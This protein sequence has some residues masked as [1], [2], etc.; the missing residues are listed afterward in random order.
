MD[1]AHL[2]SGRSFRLSVDEETGLILDQLELDAQGKLILQ[3]TYQ[4]LDLSP[5]PTNIVWHEPTPKMLFALD[6]DLGDVFGFE[7]DLPINLPPGYELSSLESLDT[8][9]MGDDLGPWLRVTY[10]NGVDPLFYL[11]S[12]PS[13]EVAAADGDVIPPGRTSPGNLLQ[14][15]SLGRATAALGDLPLGQVMAA[16]RVSAQELGDL[17]HSAIR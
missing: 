17:I 6:A 12:I 7:I 9:A 3:V 5:N 1:V 11:L 16:G 4:S 14:I 10:T 13:A 15:M 2:R 8:T